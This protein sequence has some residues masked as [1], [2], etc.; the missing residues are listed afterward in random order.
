MTKC[1]K[2]ERWYFSGNKMNPDINNKEKIGKY[3]KKL[4]K[5]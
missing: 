4:L 5:L 1:T 2:A 3:E